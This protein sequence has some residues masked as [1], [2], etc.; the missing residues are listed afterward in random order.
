MTRILLTE[1]SQKAQRRKVS[2]FTSSLGLC[3]LGT[4]AFHHC[5]RALPTAAT[6]FAA[7]C[8]TLGFCPEIHSAGRPPNIVLLVADDLGYGEL[9]CQGNRQIPTPHIDSVASGGVRFTHGY[10]TAPV[11]SPS[12]AGLLTGRYQTRFGHELNA[13]GPQNKE[14]NV[15]LPLGE[16]TLAD[17]LKSTGYATACIGK[18][19]LGGSEEYHP[20]HR[21]FDTFFGFLHEGHTFAPPHYPGLI[22][23][24]RRV[25]PPYDEGNS[26]LRGSQPIEEEEY[27]T[28]A[29]THEAIRF[30][31]QH[32]ERPF[33]L[34]VP[35]N[36]VH[37]PMQTTPR[38]FDRFSSIG[39]I[40]RRVFAAMLSALDDSVGA[41]LA[42]L[43][44]HSLDENTLIIFLS[45]NGGPTAELTSSNLPL[46]GGKG[47]MY[48][49]GI[50]VP[51]VMRW[52][53]KLPPDRVY[54][55]PVIS[56]DMFA[57]AT[58]AAGAKLPANLRLDGVDLL[59]HLTDA[60][61]SPPHE[62]LFWRYGNNYALRQANWK[63]V[64]QAPPR[65]ATA[66]PQL[67]DLSTDVVEANDLA[68]QRPEVVSRLQAAWDKF[69]A[70]MVPPRWSR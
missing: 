27:F 64:R 58:A 37:S 45:D 29:I 59:P 11:C 66:R 7:L 16:V 18:W 38:Y 5:S 39:D 48:E 63:L 61:V 19:H 55:Q 52:K 51:L 35:Y 13:I 36:A 68:G 30:I 12:R 8:V 25:E 31:D 1:K 47:Q 69:N 57:T 41:I 33:F 22:S 6:Y 23:H 49:G 46:R 40:H 44:E 21:G 70:E 2:H 20:Q 42:K 10:V 62:M 53:G 43:L 34:Y 56:L 28:E 4:F 26:L 3:A 54:E 17:V 67:F 24:F 50:R 65:N 60:K 32:R 15:G 9:G 14:P